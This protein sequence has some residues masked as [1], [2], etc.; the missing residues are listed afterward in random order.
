MAPRMIGCG[1]EIMNERIKQIVRV[2]DAAVPVLLAL[3]MTG[4]CLIFA[5]R[6]TSGVQWPYEW[7]AFRDIGAAQTMLDG[8]YPEDPIMRGETLWYN[9]LTAACNAAFSAATGV[10]LPRANVLL[11]PWLQLLTPAGFFVLMWVLFGRWAAV[12]GLAAFLFGKTGNIPA[13]NC[14]TYSPWL[15]A[16]VFA[17]GF[18]YFTLAGFVLVRRKCPA[19]LAGHAMVG[20]LLALTFMTHTAPAVNA[21]GVMAVVIMIAL[22]R[23]RKGAGIK[24]SGDRSQEAETQT[25]EVPEPS[26]GGG[27]GAWR[28]AG[29]PFLLLLAVAFAGSLPYTWSILRD[30]H[31]HVRNPW[32]GLYASSYVELAQFHERLWEACNWRNLVAVLGAA[33]VLMRA[34]WRSAALVPF[35]W[36]GLAAF[37]LAQ[38]YAAQALLAHGVLTTTL[39]P[40]HHAAIYLTAARWV[41]FGA[42]AAALARGLVDLVLRGTWRGGVTAT[43]ANAVCCVMLLAAVVAELFALRPYR[44]WL[45]MSIT[46]SRT[47][48][49]VLYESKTDMYSWILQNTDPHAVFLTDED[50]VGLQVVMPA[51]RK[52]AGSMLLYLNPYVDVQPLMEDRRKM[53]QAMHDDDSAQFQEIA[54]RQGV[55]H[56]L[57]RDK[58]PDGAPAVPPRFFREVH[59]AG[60]LVAY[61]VEAATAAG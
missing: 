37:F 39:V 24:Q 3:G 23:M 41:F 16:P 56:F 26:V 40:G 51:A 10:P 11:G 49:A 25:A 2:I 22:W 47:E 12:L 55:T 13:W 18:F 53:L 5:L 57:G 14:A 20:L 19:S 9:P 27:A 15:F 59:R 35:A 33:A 43:L 48:Y 50:G 6:A 58:G 30:Y 4:Y 32:P 54:H 60:G 42:G 38:N 31:F 45:E 8:R 29:L 7:D 21:G 17:E 36:V 44:D 34:E 61:E 52:L 28:G 46:H 1:V